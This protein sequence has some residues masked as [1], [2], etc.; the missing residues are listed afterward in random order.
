ME[1]DQV[2]QLTN[3]RFSCG[4]IFSILFL[5]SDSFWPPIIPTLVLLSSFVSNCGI[6]SLPVTLLICFLDL[7][8][9]AR[10]MGQPSI[11]LKSAES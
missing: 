6:K 8:L 9:A 7:I 1:S 5:N 10:A 11:K 2:S 4:N 3:C